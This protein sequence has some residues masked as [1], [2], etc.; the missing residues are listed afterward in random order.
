[1]EDL[2]LLLDNSADANYY[3][4]LASKCAKSAGLPNSFPS[5][6][7]AQFCTG[8]NCPKITPTELACP[9]Q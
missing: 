7:A 8:G 9:A 6:G 1:M 5:I 3:R 4:D 2:A